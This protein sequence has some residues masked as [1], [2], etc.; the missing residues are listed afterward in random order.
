MGTLPPHL[1]YLGVFLRFRRTFAEVN[2]F[3]GASVH[4]LAQFL[5]VAVFEIGHIHLHNMNYN[6]YYYKFIVTV[7]CRNTYIIYVN[8]IVLL[9]YIYMYI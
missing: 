2:T 3:G 7:T 8:G 1:N 6:I 4:I 5:I 9:L